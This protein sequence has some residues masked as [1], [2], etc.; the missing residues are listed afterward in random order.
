LQ[1]V[2]EEH[3]RQTALLERNVARPPSRRDG[4]VDG[5]TVAVWCLVIL[6]FFVGLSI[7]GPIGAVALALI[8]GFPIVRY[9]DGRP[10]RQRLALARA[11]LSSEHQEAL[12]DLQKDIRDRW[13]ALLSVIKSHSGTL[14]AERRRLMTPDKWGRI[15]GTAEWEEERRAFVTDVLPTLVNCAGI[16]YPLR[17]LIPDAVEELVLARSK[18]STVA[19]TG[20]LSGEEFEH[21]CAAVLESAGW[22]V[23]MT[24]RSGDQGIDLVAIKNGWSVAIQC[25]RYDKPVGNAAVQEARAGLEFYGCDAA[26]VVAD[27][28]FTKSAHELAASTAVRLFSPEQLP[29]MEPW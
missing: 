4:D 13:N 22:Q 14:A 25:K 16:G 3:I 27:K 29:H 2:V 5:T 18:E 10:E 26:A 23:R 11:E 12:K 6:L 20:L 1:A 15:V 24:P 21:H 28:G 8:G 7:G 9:A 19:R 17:A